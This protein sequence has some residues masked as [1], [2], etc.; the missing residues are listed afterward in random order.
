M[1]ESSRKKERYFGLDFLRGIC[2]L[3]VVIYHIKSWRQSEGHGVLDGLLAWCGLYGVS[4]FFLL[5]GYSLAIAYEQKFLRGITSPVLYRYFKRRV[6]RIFPLFFFV[7][8]ISSLGRITVSGNPVLLS[9]FFMNVF[10]LFGF[11]DSTATPVVGGWSIGVEMVFYLILPVLLIAKGL[12]SWLFVFFSFGLTVW[13]SEFVAQGNSLESGWASYAAPANHLVFFV[14]GVFLRT[15]LPSY[16]VSDRS[17]LFGVVLVVACV[18][19]LSNGKSELELVVGPLRLVMIVLASVVVYLFASI[20]YL[21]LAAV[22]DFLGRISYPLYLIHP[23]VYF[24]GRNIYQY[25][26]FSMF[27]VMVLCVLAATVLDYFFDQP[28]QRWLARSGW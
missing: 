13:V 15:K 25:L 17:V 10:L 18:A 22:S 23:I 7:L 14:I 2:A 26:G 4:I 19:Y 20:K 27:E 9:E 3:I 12:R 21:G 24:G 6:G 8:I 16:M 1:F 5:S 11:F 28:V